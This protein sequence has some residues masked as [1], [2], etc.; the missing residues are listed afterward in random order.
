MANQTLRGTSR[1]LLPDYDIESWLRHIIQK[2]PFKSSLTWVKGHQDS[3]KSNEPLTHDAQLNIAVN[4]LADYAYSEC[5][6][7]QDTIAPFDTTIISLKL[8]SSRVTSKMKSRI[9]ES[10]YLEPL[11]KYRTKKYNWNNHTWHTI[12]WAAYD[13]AQKQAGPGVPRFLHQFVNE[14][15]P[16]GCCTKY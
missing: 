10:I 15:L 8:G 6:P 1:F 3:T 11:K 14:W 2:A 5:T 16:V 13:T 4:E 12:D 7:S 9:E